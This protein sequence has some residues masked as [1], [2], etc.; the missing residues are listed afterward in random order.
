MPAC[1]KRRFSSTVSGVTGGST[2]D[3]PSA[4]IAAKVRYALQTYSDSEPP[5]GSDHTETPTSIDFVNTRFTQALTVRM[6]P[7]RT[8]RRNTRLSM[9]T[10]TTALRVCLIALIAAV[11]SMMPARRP[12]NRLPMWL[13][14]DCRMISDD[15]V[16]ETKDGCAGGVEGISMFQK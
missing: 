12:P 15:S 5:G 2:Y 14:S 16:R 11:R 1:S 3:L 4:S 8:G 10:V 9:D 7:S 6:E 13:R